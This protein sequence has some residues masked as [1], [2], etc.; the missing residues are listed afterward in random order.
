MA[1]LR[2]GRVGY[3]LLTITTLVSGIV[4]QEPCS[5]VLCCAAARLR[6]VVVAC[7]ISGG[8]IS[9]PLPLPL[10]TSLAFSCPPTGDYEN[11][12]NTIRDHY[13]H[14]LFLVSSRLSPPLRL[15]LVLPVSDES[16]TLVSFD[17]GIILSPT[18]D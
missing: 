15:S 5:A 7:K 16:L 3:L 2:R 9:L 1:Y 11:Y 4:A 18:T 14:C 8:D 12:E 6:I 13:Y 17:Q 10:C